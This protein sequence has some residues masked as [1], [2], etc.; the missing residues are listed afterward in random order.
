MT[1][2]NC[3]HCG[4]TLAA[5]DDAGAGDTLQCGECGVDYEL[6]REDDVYDLVVFVCPYCDY[7]NK[8]SQDVDR[9]RCEDEDCNLEFD[10]VGADTRPVEEDELRVKMVRVGWA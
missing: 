8:R 1:D 2:Y 4:N 10:P 6:R 7:P 3:T 9:A 5:E